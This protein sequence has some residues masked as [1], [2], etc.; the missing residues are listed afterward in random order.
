MKRKMISDNAGFS[1]VEL[2]IVIA[3]MAVLAAAIAPAIIRYIVKARKAVDIANAEAIGSSLNA[4]ITSDEELYDYVSAGAKE[5]DPRVPSKKYRILGY[6]SV[7]TTN[8]GR[9]YN[10]SFHTPRNLVGTV[11][12]QGAVDKFTELMTKEVGMELVKLHFGDFTI[13]DQW[14]VCCDEEGNLCVFVTSGLNGWQ[15]FVHEN[16]TVSGNG[17]TRNAYMLWPSVDERYNELNSV[18]AALP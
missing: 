1:L 7:S 10:Y 9:K 2:I 16:R 8:N 12:T 14:C 13:L 11:T 4:A 15:Y 17:G 6:S 5:C 18:S 3:I